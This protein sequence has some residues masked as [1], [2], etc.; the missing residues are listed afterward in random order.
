M[1]WWWGPGPG[2]HS[3]SQSRSGELGEKPAR[4]PRPGRR[5][6]TSL[7]PVSP[8]ARPGSTGRLA[9]PSGLPELAETAARP[10]GAPRR[11]QSP[12]P[13]S[14]AGQCRPPVRSAAVLPDGP[15]ALRFWRRLRNLSEVAVKGSRSQ[16]AL[17]PV[18]AQNLLVS[19]GR[20]LPLSP[21]RTRF[22][23]KLEI[24]CGLNAFNP[25]RR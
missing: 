23:T 16:S 21:S 2:R 20:D 5:D 8:P 15:C 19:R 10:G 14:A 22:K 13:A 3:V 9:A 12:G 4:S 17:S 18:S 6:V 11:A 7:R 1:D 24:I 25:G